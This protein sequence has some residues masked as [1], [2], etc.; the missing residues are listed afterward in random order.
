MISH[1]TIP[2]GNPPSANT[3]N[4]PIL[5]T[6]DSTPTITV[7]HQAQGRSLHSPTPE[8]M[9][10]SENN[11][12]RAPRIKNRPP[13]SGAI[14]ASNA[15]PRST[16][17]PPRRPIIP[18]RIVKIARIA[19]PMGRLGFIGGGAYIGG[20]GGAAGGAIVA[21]R[22]PRAS[23]KHYLTV[24]IKTGERPFPSKPIGKRGEH[25][26]R[27]QTH[28]PCSQ[29]GL[30]HGLARAGAEAQRSGPMVAE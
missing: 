3:A 16:S 8:T 5:N 26:R 14:V 21:M 30:P 24:A 12:T 17:N 18:N 20:G 22:I 25:S 10:N 1:R 9:P 27:V 29:E 6:I 28:L 15:P 7:S 19:T 4:D 11:V 23:G 2:Y 13:N